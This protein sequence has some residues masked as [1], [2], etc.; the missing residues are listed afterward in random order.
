MAMRALRTFGLEDGHGVLFAV[1]GCGH[2]DEEMAAKQ[3]A[4]ST[5]LGRSEGSAGPD[6]DRSD[7][8]QRREPD[9]QASRSPGGGAEC[10]TVRTT[11]RACSVERIQATRRSACRHRGALPR[12]PH[13]AREVAEGRREVRRP[14]QSDGDRATGRRALRLGQGRASRRRRETGIGQVAEVIRNDKD[15][16]ARTF[17]VAGH[18]DDAKYPPR[19]PLHGQLGALARARS[20]RA[21]L[22]VAR[23]R[24]QAAAPSKDEQGGGLDP[25][26]WSAAGF[27][28][29]QPEVG[30]GTAA[31]RKMSGAKNRRV[32]T[33]A[34]AQRR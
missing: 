27:G 9:R 26:K 22:L 20:H 30:E 21:S 13:P 7:G 4:R 16:S 17:Q 2:T 19:R 15:L 18:T 34:S 24:D 25:T 12:A 6:R 3:R 14:Q 8:A 33:R 5:S 1:L 23:S 28:E 10:A 32:G 11:L 29:T 31:R